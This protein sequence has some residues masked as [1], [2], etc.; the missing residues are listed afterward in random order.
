MVWSAL[1]KLHPFSAVLVFDG[2]FDKGN[3]KATNDPTDNNN[4]F[5]RHMFSLAYIYLLV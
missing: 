5:T 2:F 3:N 4:Y 1:T